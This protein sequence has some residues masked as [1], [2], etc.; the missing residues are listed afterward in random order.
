MRKFLFIGL[1]VLGCTHSE[2]ASEEAVPKEGYEIKKSGQR[3]KVEHDC[4]RW[5]NPDRE[6]MLE[7]GVSL[8]LGGDE[9]GPLQPYTRAGCEEATRP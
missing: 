4:A 8:E 9:P 5:E 6:P 3:I 1:C 2:E 7:M